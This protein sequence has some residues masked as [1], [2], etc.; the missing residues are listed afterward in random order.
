[1]PTNV[2]PDRLSR[3]ASAA[4]AALAFALLGLQGCTSA[5]DAKS[6]T[7]DIGQK[8]LQ[9]EPKPDPQQPP[10][11]PEPKPEPKPEPEPRDYPPPPT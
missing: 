8:P 7:K 2:S 4:L 9:A 5:P 3:R 11:P 1:M 10:P 6:Q